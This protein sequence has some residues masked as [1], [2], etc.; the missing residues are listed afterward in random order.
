MD[1]KEFAIANGCTIYKTLIN[2]DPLSNAPNHI[3][4]TCGDLNIKVSES[5]FTGKP[6]FVIIN[7]TIC[8]DINTWEKLSSRIHE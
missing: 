7:D 4:M 1:C 3:W 5:I 8:N 2:K 6:Y